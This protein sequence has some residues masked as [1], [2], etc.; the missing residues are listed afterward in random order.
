MITVHKTEEYI[1]STLKAGVNGYILKDA[2]Y[3]ELMLAVDNIS[4]G[5]SYL[6]PGILGKAIKGYLEGR[7]SVKSSTSFGILT[8]RECEILKMVAEGCKNKY[9]AGYLC[10]SAKTVEK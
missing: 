7:K 3:S 4:S 9:I 1:L 8:R 5:R 2:T 10:I 6:S